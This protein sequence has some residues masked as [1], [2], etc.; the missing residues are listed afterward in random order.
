MLYNN[1]Y[2]CL[3]SMKIATTKINVIAM[4]AHTIKMIKVIMWLDSSAITSG[5]F[6]EGFGKPSEKERRD[7]Y[8]Y[9]SF[10]EYCVN[11]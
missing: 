7:F 3:Q 6:V 10:V 9:P 4:I 2:S 11:L 8:F 1:T 5:R